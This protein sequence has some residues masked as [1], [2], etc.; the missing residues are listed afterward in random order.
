MLINKIHV[1]EPVLITM[2]VRA[3]Y[4][5]GGLSVVRLSVARYWLQLEVLVIQ[6][7]GCIGLISFNKLC[8]IRDPVYSQHFF[9]F[10]CFP[11][12]IFLS[13]VLR[14]Q[15]QLINI[16]WTNYMAL[17]NTYSNFHWQADDQHSQCQWRTVDSL[18]L[19]KTSGH[20][21]RMHWIKGCFFFLTKPGTDIV[22]SWKDW[23]T[24]EHSTWS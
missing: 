13:K 11:R 14:Y 3:L 12:N 4:G 7:P 21:C 17:P 10:S 16:R 19:S 2:R 1:H 15:V 23:L 20:R 8:M 18:I 24:L 6:F 9:Y 22:D 5:K